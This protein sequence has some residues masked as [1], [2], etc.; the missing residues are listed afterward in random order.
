MGRRQSQDPE[1]KKPRAFRL[2]L[3]RDPDHRKR[4]LRRRLENEYEDT[5]I[6]GLL[7]IVLLLI[8]IVGMGLWRVFT[9]EWFP[10]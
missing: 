7:A 8:A 6:V 2:W 3:R 10:G 9:G 5:H 1:G 4:A